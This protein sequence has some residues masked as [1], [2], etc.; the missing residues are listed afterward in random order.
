MGQSHLENW[1][2]SP[3]K[4]FAHVF[5]NSQENEKHHLVRGNSAVDLLNFWTTPSC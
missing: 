2:H 5:S 3:E 4:G 1:T